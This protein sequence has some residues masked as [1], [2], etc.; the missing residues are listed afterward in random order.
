MSAD[1]TVPAGF[2]IDVEVSDP[3]EL[4]LLREHLRRM[5]GIQVSQIAGSAG[6]SEQGTA[7]SLQI[8]SLIAGP[9]LAVAV[10]TLPEFVRSRR[11][12][13]RITLKQDEREVEIELDNTAEGTD[14]QA[15]VDKLLRDA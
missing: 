8:V 5:P 3:R 11:S 12:H 1:A 2:I 6:P 7:D 14:V 15:L 9:S 10:R 13:L 4:P